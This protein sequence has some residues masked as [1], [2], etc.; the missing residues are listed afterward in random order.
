M[1]S[2]PVDPINN[3]GDAFYTGNYSYSYGW[4]F[5]SPTHTYDLIAHLENKSDPDR[6]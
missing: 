4:H 5:S 2:I 6:C 1:T 3:A